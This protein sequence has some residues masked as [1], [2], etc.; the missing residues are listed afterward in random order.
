MP[1]IVETPTEINET[2]P[3]HFAT[4]SEAESRAN[5][6]GGEG[7]H[8]HNGFYMP[9]NTHQQYLDAINSDDESKKKTL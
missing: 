7:S 3:D 8:S 2:P 5:Q 4:Q 1:D 9:F 6:M